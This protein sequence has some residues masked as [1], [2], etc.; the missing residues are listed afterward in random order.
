MGHL[1]SRWIFLI[2]ISSLLPFIQRSQSW[3]W[4]S[5]TIG[6][7]CDLKCPCGTGV[8]VEKTDLSSSLFNFLPPPPSCYE[9]MQLVSFQTSSYPSS[10]QCQLTWNCMSTF[11]TSVTLRSSQNKSR[12]LL[13]SLH[14]M[15]INSSTPSM[16]SS[17]GC[18]VQKKE[19]QWYNDDD[20]FQLMSWKNV[21]MQCLLSLLNQQVMTILKMM[22]QH[23]LIV[24]K[25][26]CSIFKA[27]R[28]LECYTA[29]KRSLWS[30]KSHMTAWTS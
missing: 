29:H 10:K 17:K 2:V 28:F 9:S 14:I 20:F 15:K 21:S 7:E 18:F 11:F 26:L 3:L 13:Q 19:R 5:I 25:K 1:R 8:T 24:S 16:L 30:M 23:S 27:V 6:L 22:A 12:V 4:N